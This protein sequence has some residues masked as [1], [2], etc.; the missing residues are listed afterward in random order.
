MAKRA[1]K[2]K[3]VR[4]VAIGSALATGA[5]VVALMPSANAANV[6]TP[7]EIMAM[8]DESSKVNGVQ[9]EVRSGTSGF[10]ADTCDF[11]ETK[12]EIFNGPTEKVTI[13]FPNCE[14]NA[15]EPAKVTTEWKKEVAQGQ[16]KYT[17][18]QQGGIGGLF[19]ALN[20]QWL[21][22]T[23]TLDMTVRT[24]TAS[25]KEERSV[26][27]GKVLAVEFTPKMHRMTGFWRVKIDAF[28]DGL[29]PEHPAETYEADD[30][31][32]GPVIR[33]SAAGT[34]QLADG[35]SKPVLTDC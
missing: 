18:T 9:Q 16:G 34:P 29:G 20:L 12:F 10:R 23:G 22:H 7:E 3:K 19:G 13:D 25:E 30:V 33:P 32:E 24:T 28:S 31:I 4:L 27:V 26:P 17:S 6:K 21:K 5:A 8:C 2:N 15:T 35:I 1:L 14:P 11:I